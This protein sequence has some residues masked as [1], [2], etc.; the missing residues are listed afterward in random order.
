MPRLPAA[1]WHIRLGIRGIHASYP[2]R[3]DRKSSFVT[4]SAVKL[5]HFC[6]GHRL[7]KHKGKCARLHGHNAVAEIHCQAP[8]LDARRMV[9]DFEEITLALKSWIDEALDHRMILNRA[10][11][12]AP[13][14]TA[15]GEKFFSLDGDPTAEAIAKLIFDRAVLAK[16]PIRKVVLWETPTSFVIYER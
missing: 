16:L 10:D 5:I 15:S 7:L 6:Y 2:G 11:P 12:I 4:Y 14:L 1:Y 9:V 13:V 8:E 3:F